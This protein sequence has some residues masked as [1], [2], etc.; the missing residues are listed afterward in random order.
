[1]LYHILGEQVT[2]NTMNKEQ[3]SIFSV[4]GSGFS[5]VGLSDHFYFQMPGKFAKG[6][7]KNID[8]FGNLVDTLPESLDRQILSI[9]LLKNI[10]NGN[11]A[12]I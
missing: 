7:N 10:R 5:K 4:S 6:D 3:G 9:F 11:I 2:V 12:N 8:Q 1:M